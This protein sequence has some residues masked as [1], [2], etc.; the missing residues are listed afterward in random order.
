[1]I[2]P[3]QLEQRYRQIERE[4]MAGLPMLN[5]ALSVRAL[6]FREFEGR[7]LGALLTPWFMNLML[8]P[9]EDDRWCEGDSGEKRRLLLPSGSY[10]FIHGWDAHFGGY[11]ACSL[12]SPVFEF[13]DQAAAEATAGAALAALF[14]AAEPATDV[15]AE[16]DL[17]GQP[18]QLSRRGF[19][20]GL[21]GGSAR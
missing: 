2:G 13:A 4:Q 9:G 11:C 17:A 18:Q 3:A 15:P 1:M 14:Q 19:L 5:P 6:G 16:K 8:L 20:T 7:R 10:E 12:F 21:A